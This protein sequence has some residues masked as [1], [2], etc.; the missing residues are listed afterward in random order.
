M[1]SHLSCLHLFSPVF[2]L[3]LLSYLHCLAWHFRLSNTDQAHLTAGCFASLFSFPFRF[4]YFQLTTCPLQ[5]L[6]SPA[7]F[8]LSAV[9]LC[10]TSW[11]FEKCSFFCLPSRYFAAPW[12]QRVFCSSRW[13]SP[14]ETLMWVSLNVFPFYPIFFPSL[15]ISF[16]LNLRWASGLLLVVTCICLP[17]T[18]PIIYR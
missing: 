3:L 12:A 7:Y 13:V 17:H 14:E 15:L 18:H 6:P 2:N 10:L 5:I 11:Y 1:S 4:C 9:F 8:L 16:S